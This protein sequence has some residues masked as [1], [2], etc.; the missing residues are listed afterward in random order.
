MH[1]K[2]KAIE[3]SAKHA[4]V[5]GVANEA[6]K[7]NREAVDIFGKKVDSLGSSPCYRLVLTAPPIDQLTKSDQ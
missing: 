6:S 5:A 4:G 3:A 1:A 2:E 7:K